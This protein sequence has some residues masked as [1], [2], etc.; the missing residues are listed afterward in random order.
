[1]GGM[2]FRDRVDAGQRLVETLRSQIGGLVRLDA[3]VVLGLP[4]GGVPVAYEIAQGLDAS[5]DVILVRKLGVPSQP[6]LAMGAIGEDG[7]RVVNDAVIRSAR[8]SE[9]LL[10]TIVARERAELERRA[11]RIR[12]VH[13]RVELRD[14]TAVIV[15]D[16]IATGA[17][18]RAAC[19][20]ARVQGASRVVVAAPVAPPTTVAQLHDV[21]D[22]VVVTETPSRFLA[23]GEF[24]RDFS[25]TTEDEVLQ[26]LQR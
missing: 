21:A 2:P 26:L 12:R 19:E 11:T 6:E 8:I 18:M 3:S 16:G 5:L 15:D 17:T 7:V 22:A 13:P 24:Y 4:R 25:A 10:D 20:V 14:R 1:M 23:I 9:E